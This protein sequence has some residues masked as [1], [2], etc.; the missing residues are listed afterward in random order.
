MEAFFSLPVEIQKHTLT[1]LEPCELDRLFS[2]ASLQPLEPQSIDPYT[3]TRHLA[4]AAKF[5]NKRVVLSNYAKLATISFQELDYL[6]AHS[7]SISPSDITFAFFDFTNYNETFA[8]TK[9]LFERYLE[10]LRF[11]TSNFNIRLILVE[12]VPL[13]N[14]FLKS[15]FQPLCCGDLNVLFTIKYAPGF[16]QDSRLLRT[17]ELEVSMAKLLGENSEI[18]VESLLLHLFDS[19]NLIK[20]FVA[21]NGCFCCQGLRVLDLSY[22]N[23]TDLHLASVEFPPGLQHLNLSNNQ[24]QLIDNNTFGYRNL[25]SLKSL[26]LSN[27]NIMNIRLKNIPGALQSYQLSHLK[28]SG[29]ILASYE[30][31]ADCSF[32]ENVRDLDLSRNLLDTLTAIIPRVRVLDLTGNYFALSTETVKNVFPPELE[33][34]KISFSVPPEES[35]ELSPLK[36]TDI[37]IEEALLQSLKELYVCGF[38]EVI[39]Y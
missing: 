25:T 39:L 27:N 5:H 15:I 2:L 12:N 34:L 21:D 19:N 3:Q 31:L 17:N 6:L 29:N 16:A 11:F 23:L 30:S 36:A 18:A 22:N 28:L 9:F 8:F 14:N 26:D 4:L 35:S 13:E 33:V 7:I 24:L 38:P 32:F 37:L 20:H 10:N 1:F